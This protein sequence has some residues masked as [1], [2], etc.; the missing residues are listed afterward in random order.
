[1]GV[2]AGKLRLG[3]VAASN[4]GEF[5]KKFDL[6]GERDRM[7]DREESSIGFGPALGYFP[8]R[9]PSRQARSRSTGAKSKSGART[10]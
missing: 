6:L 1:M 4:D 9:T 10:R 8:A 5:R 7:V 2:V 3:T